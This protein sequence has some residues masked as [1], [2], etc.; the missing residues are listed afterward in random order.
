[1]L[2][3]LFLTDLFGDVH[4]KGSQAGIAIGK[5][6]RELADSIYAFVP[7]YV[8]LHS[9]LPG[10]N[11]LIKMFKLD[12]EIRVHEA[13]NRTSQHLVGMFSDEHLK[14][15]IHEHESSRLILYITDSPVGIQKILQQLD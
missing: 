10:C 9:S 2:Q 14:G 15:G 12:G 4:H 1:M 6:K 11:L 13:R 5:D 7:G 8:L 3:I